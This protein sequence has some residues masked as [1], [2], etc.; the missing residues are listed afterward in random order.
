ML[1][2]CDLLLSLRHRG[3]SGLSSPFISLSMDNL[4]IE[5]GKTLDLGNER[6]RK[7]SGRD[8]D[9][10]EPFLPWPSI[11]RHGQGPS[12]SIGRAI[13]SGDM[14]VESAMLEEVEVHGVRFEV[15][16]HLGSRG[17]VWN[18]W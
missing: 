13:D 14:N 15:V 1:Q 6:R 9:F 8:Q 10:V 4:P 17:V 7:G 5:F 11:V 16:E 18:I 3:V 2:T 12:L